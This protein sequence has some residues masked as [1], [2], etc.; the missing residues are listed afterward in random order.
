MSKLF[1]INNRDTLNSRFISLFASILD[2]AYQLLISDSEFSF[3]QLLAVA[4]GAKLSY[5]ITQYISDEKG[6]ILNKIG[7]RKK[8][9]KKPRGINGD[10]FEFDDQ[11]FTMDSVVFYTSDLV[12]DEPVDV[13]LISQT[14]TGQWVSFSQSISYTDLESLYFEIEED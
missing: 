12:F 14:P 9:K 13:M 8:R 1:N 6:A 11:D 10:A 2:L 4:L 5:L 7:G 3:L